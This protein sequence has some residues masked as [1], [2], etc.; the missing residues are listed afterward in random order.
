MS[1]IKVVIDTS[2]LIDLCIGDL[3]ESF[4]NL[5]FAFLI[6]DVIKEEFSQP[7]ECLI[8]I[9]KIKVCSL[10]SKDVQKVYDFSIAYKGPSINDYFSLV[11]AEK[12]DAILVTGDRKLR[13]IGEK[14]GI[15][16]H[17][18]LWI[19]DI[20]FDKKYLNGKTLIKALEKILEKG[21]RLPKDE[22]EKRIKKWGGK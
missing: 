19:M 8:E 21:A 20:L 14:T 17:G 1:K 2:I 10:E 22:C 7:E 12:E 3:M 4:L 6:P 16:V 13:N 5:P 9:E 11:L 15:E 18:I